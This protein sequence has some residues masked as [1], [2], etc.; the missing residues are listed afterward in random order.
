MP[1]RAVP[2]GK[3]GSARREPGVAIS[4]AVIAV[5]EIVSVEVAAAPFKAMDGDEKLHAAPVGRPAHVSI[6]VPLNPPP[7][8]RVIMVMAD[9][10]GAMEPAVEF[11]AMV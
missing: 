2:A 3:N 8:V 9:A 7:G 5:V 1:A 6:T 4:C 11:A 10:P